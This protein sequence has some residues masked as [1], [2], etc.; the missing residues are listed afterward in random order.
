MAHATV[1]RQYR[2]TEREA[3]ARAA[4]LL[5]GTGIT[6]ATM[7]AATYAYVMRTLRREGLAD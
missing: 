4:Q 2:R 1:T 5:S 7:D 3:N 6:I